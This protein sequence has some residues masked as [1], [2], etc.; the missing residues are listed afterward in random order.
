VT[1]SEVGS[2]QAQPRALEGEVLAL[3]ISLLAL[4]Q[5]SYS[6][7]AGNLEVACGD[8]SCAKT[9][10]VPRRN[11]P[12]CPIVPIANPSLLPSISPSYLVQYHSLRR[13]VL[14]DITN[15]ASYLFPAIPV[16]SLYLPIH[17]RTPSPYRHSLATKNVL[18]L[19]CTSHRTSSDAIT[20]FKDCTVLL[21]TPWN[22]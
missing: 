9:A 19:V 2:S 7:A 6:T 17:S 8:H 13:I 21:G 3:L 10:P 22:I 5:N 16:S 11:P 4:S 12:T 18:R 20:P 15:L 1:L 14:I